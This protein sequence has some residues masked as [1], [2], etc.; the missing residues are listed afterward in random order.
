MRKTHHSSPSVPWRSPCRAPTRSRPPRQALEHGRQEEGRR[1]DEVRSPAP[2]ADA[3]RWGDVEVTIVV[4]KTTTTVGDEED[5]RAEDHR[6][7]GAGLAE[8]HRPLDLHQP[9][10]AADSDPGDPARRRAR[11]IY[12]VSGATDSSDAFAQSLQSAIL[13]AKAWKQR[14]H[15]RR[16]CDGDARRRRRP[17]PGRRRR[18]LDACSTGC[19]TGCA[20]STRRSA[21]TRTTARSAASI[22][23]SSRVEDAHPDVREV[24][25]RC[26][27]LR[28]ETRRLLRR[29]RRVPRACSTRPASSR[30]GRSTAPPAILDAAGLRNYSSTRAATWSCAAARSR[31]TAGAS[32][33]S[34]RWSATRSRRSS[35]RRARRRDVGRLRARR[36]R[37]RPAHAAA[38]RGRAL[39]DDHRAGARDGGR[40]RHRGVRDGRSTGRSGRRGCAATR[41]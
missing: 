30:A 35:R 16:A 41:R 13:S 2:P 26:E 22:A 8:P 15:P 34:I 27:E 18:G 29:P 6:G 1:R 36:A 31:T 14:V 9:A 20:S 25:E 11:D 32:A 3:D 37:A 23:A 12:A 7:D 17:R 24:L 33:S 40:V 21:P 4:K 10:G 5:R 28:E 38:A 39:G 19:S